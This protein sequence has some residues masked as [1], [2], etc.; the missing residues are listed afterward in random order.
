L[1][2]PGEHRE[3]VDDHDRPIGVAPNVEVSLVVN[4]DDAS[5]LAEPSVGHYA[6]EAF[7]RFVRIVSRPVFAHRMR[8][9]A[10]A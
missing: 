3:Q 9:Y 4:P 5:M 1:Q 8:P 7:R 10:R 2:I 6:Y